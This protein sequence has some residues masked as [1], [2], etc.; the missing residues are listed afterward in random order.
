MA[1]PDYQ[2][3][4][5]PVLR[6]AAGGETRVP[7][8][9]ENIADELG[10]SIPE[11]DDLLPSGRQRVLHNRIHWSKFYMSKAGLI[12]FPSR[13]RFVAT[14]AGQALL[15]LQ[16]GPLRPQPTLQAAV[17]AAGNPTRVGSRCAFPLYRRSA[18]ANV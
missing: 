13:G 15:D 4:M 9:A 17:Y 14:N 2:A 5:L 3:R 8:V 12:V 7:E 6:H 1:I 16:Q 18:V 10:L 11:H